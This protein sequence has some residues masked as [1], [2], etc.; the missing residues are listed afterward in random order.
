MP[1]DPSHN[2]V[3]VDYALS[4]ITNSPRP[5]QPR[6]LRVV[7]DPLD[8]PLND[9]FE[10]SDDDSERLVVGVC[11]ICSNLNE[12]YQSEVNEHVEEI[13]YKHVTG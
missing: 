9:M 6:Q 4:G 10:E 8:T 13:I 2:L 11:K 3:V 1:L 12:K 5:L 7:P